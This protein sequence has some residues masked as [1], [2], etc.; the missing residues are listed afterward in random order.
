VI[1]W[2]TNIATLLG[3]LAIGAIVYGGLLMTLSVGEDEKV[4]K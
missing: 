4:K 1:N 2:T 3:L